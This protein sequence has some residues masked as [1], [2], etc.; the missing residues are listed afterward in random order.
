MC[1]C[2]CV[3]VCVCFTVFDTGRSSPIL[4][5]ELLKTASRNL[6]RLTG[7]S[8]LPCSDVVTELQLTSRRIYENLSVSRQCFIYM[9]ERLICLF[10]L[11]EKILP[12]CEARLILLM[13]TVQGIAN[14]TAP[15]T[16]DFA[17]VCK[18]LIGFVG[19]IYIFFKCDEMS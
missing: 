3:C 8:N 14:C 16:R 1:V 5:L 17:M 7:E 19:H 10:I 6:L 4:I 12:W 11:W 18:T 15:S 9:Y 13:Q 2:V